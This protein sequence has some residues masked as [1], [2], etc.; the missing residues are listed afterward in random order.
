MKR[1]IKMTPLAQ[2]ATWCKLSG[3]G[4]HI[5]TQFLISGDSE[6][7][8]NVMHVDKEQ[9]GFTIKVVERLTDARY[10]CQ[11]INEGKTNIQG[12]ETGTFAWANIPMPK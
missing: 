7:G 10:L 11:L 1:F 12:C 9:C 6:D 4:I 5:P 3:D 2:Q 8:Y